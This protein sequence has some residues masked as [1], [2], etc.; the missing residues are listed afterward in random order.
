MHWGKLIFD[1]LFYFIS[2]ALPLIFSIHFVLAIKASCYVF[3][4]TFICAKFLI[5]L[6]QH[7]NVYVIHIIVIII[8]I[9]NTLL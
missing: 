1:I 5:T 8:V 2:F 3:I 6:T 7:V 9:G 4:I